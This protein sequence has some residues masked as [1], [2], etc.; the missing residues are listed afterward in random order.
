MGK[1]VS[2]RICTVNDCVR[3]HVARGYCN[4]HYG[5]IYLREKFGNSYRTFDVESRKAYS[6]QYAATN[7]HN[8]VTAEHIDSKVLER[9]WSKVDKLTL[10]ESS[11]CWV[12]T[13]AKTA[14]RPRRKN[15]PATRGYGAITINKRPFYTHRL[16]FL[17]H[18]GYLTQ[19]LVIDHLCG[20]TLCVNPSH[21]D[22]TTNK[23]NLHKSPNFSANNS[24]KY[25]Q[26]SVCKYGHKRKPGAGKCM[27]CYK[28]KLKK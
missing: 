28:A 13:G 15:A 19:G 20:N 26:K 5:S 14:N 16:S 17:I 2:G 11:G 8:P 1:R 4:Y 25:A 23:H 27:A 12:W 10:K 6:R 18:N 24:N 7:A 3:P 9:F 22:E 21:L